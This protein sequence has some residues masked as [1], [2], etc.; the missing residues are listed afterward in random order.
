G[1]E[2]WHPEQRLPLDVALAASARSTVAVGERADLVLTESD[3]YG[4][5]SD[6]LRTMPVA[7][8]LLGG[9]FTANTL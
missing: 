7:A 5:D 3:P 4:S 8:T 1:R 6:E 9:R 2:P